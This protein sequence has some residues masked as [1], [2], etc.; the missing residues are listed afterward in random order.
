MVL[1]HSQFGRNSCSWGTYSSDNVFDWNSSHR[2][3]YSSDHRYVSDQFQT[4][5]RLLTYTV[6][7]IEYLDP[8]S[9]ATLIHVY[10]CLFESSLLKLK[11]LPILLSSTEVD[12][13]FVCLGP[14]SE[15]DEMLKDLQA[16]KRKINGCWTD[17]RL[18]LVREKAAIGTVLVL[19]LL[20]SPEQENHRSYCSDSI[21]KTKFIV[22]HPGPNIYLL[23]YH[24]QY[25]WDTCCFLAVDFWQRLSTILPM[26]VDFRQHLSTI[27]PMALPC[28]MLRPPWRAYARPRSPSLTYATVYSMFYMLLSSKCD[29]SRGYIFCLLFCR[30]LVS[31]SLETGN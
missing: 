2:G 8:W 16:D 7:S 5:F 25:L 3:I 20:N 19:M 14:V 30:F 1:V 13:A 24:P 11:P 6:H 15:L 10:Q 22:G 28:S 18:P 26:A 23:P 31:K 12:N 9:A 27:L 29:T 21:R 17:Q 4:N